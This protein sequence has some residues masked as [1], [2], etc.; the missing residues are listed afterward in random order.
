MTLF[1]F[2]RFYDGYKIIY[3][4]HGTKASAILLGALNHSCVVVPPPLPPLPPPH[5]S[6]PLRIRR[7]GCG[8]ELHQSAAWAQ[9]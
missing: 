5:Y 1:F 3:T 6:V 2:F 8:V 7:G 9:P 4:S